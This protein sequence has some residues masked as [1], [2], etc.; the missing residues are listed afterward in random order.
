MPCLCGFYPGICLTTE[1]KA[2]K[3][4][5]QSSHSTPAIRL[6][7]DCDSARDRFYTAPTLKH[8]ANSTVTL[9]HALYTANSTVTLTHAL[10]IFVSFSVSMTAIKCGNLLIKK[11]TW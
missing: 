1:E 7:Q 11:I 8:T 3:N 2:R 9:T 4:L 6:S 5:S 10:D